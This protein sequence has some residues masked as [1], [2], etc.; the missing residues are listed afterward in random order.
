MG[1]GLDGAGLL[2]WGPSGGTGGAGPTCG[3]E[4]A[5]SAPP[6]WEAMAL[7]ARQAGQW[8]SLRCLCRRQPVR[9]L[10]AVREH[11]GLIPVPVW[12]R[13]HRPPL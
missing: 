6:V 8:L 4:L 9:A 10:W 13:V 3:M 12:A 1:W 11:A 7:G 5:P 2:G